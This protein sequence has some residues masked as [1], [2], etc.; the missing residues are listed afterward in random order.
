MRLVGNEF[1]SRYRFDILAIFLKVLEAGVRR[2]HIKLIQLLCVRR[3][4]NNCI[5]LGD[6]YMKEM[7]YLTAHSTQFNFGYMCRTH[8][9]GPFR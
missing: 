6:T 7:F 8:G 1:V 4:K 2:V 5:T 9:K 3:S